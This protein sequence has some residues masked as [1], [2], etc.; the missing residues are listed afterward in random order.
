MPEEDVG[1]PQQQMLTLVSNEGKE[2]VITEEEANQSEK[3]RAYFSSTAEF[4]DIKE[5]RAKLPFSS[6]VLQV[7]VDYL[8]HKQHQGKEFQIDPKLLVPVAY[9]AK[10]LLC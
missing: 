1:P 7:V 8:K 3:L 4:A 5:K 10:Y 9:A 6:E 2:F